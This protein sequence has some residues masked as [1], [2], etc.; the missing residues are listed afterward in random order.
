MTTRQCLQPV[1]SPP[2]VGPY[3]HAVRVDDFLFCSGQIPI[4]PDTGELVPGDV[5]DQTDQV[6]RNIGVILKDQGL[7]FR[8]V[9]KTTVFLTDLS[10]FAV[11][12]EVYAG[13]FTG[14]FPARSTLQVAG[15]PKG[16]SVEMEVIAHY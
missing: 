6:L 16:A 9:V 3:H 12:N 10:D 15:L 14:D 7:D 5:R 8:N 4:H 2:A 1:G 13:Y 11:M